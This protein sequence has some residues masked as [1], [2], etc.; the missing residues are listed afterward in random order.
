MQAE[1]E[2]KLKGLLDFIIELD[3][4]KQITRQTYLA[5]GTRLEN[6]AEHSWHMAVMAFL[7]KDFYPGPLDMEHVLKMILLH[8]VV[9]IDAGDTYCY[10]RDG[11]KDKEERERKAAARI[12]GM[13]P[14]P[15]A[16]E[17]HAIWEE[18]ELMQTPEAKYAAVLD[19]LQP[20]LLN[21]RAAGRSW[22]EHGI[23]SSQC[24]ERNRPIRENAP[25]LW[26]YVEKTIKECVAKGYLQE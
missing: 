8:D 11:A 16:E 15:D 25:D 20:L 7:L 14:A 10:D 2:M 12:F 4:L 13:L 26:T 21:C 5:D 18:F 6:D 9:E 19:R 22:Q 24:L 17:M 1:K 3:K 23:K